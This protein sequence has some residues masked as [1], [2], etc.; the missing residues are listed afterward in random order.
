MPKRVSEQEL[1]QVEDLLLKHP[2]G[3][4][5]GQLRKLSDP[6]VSASTLKRRLSQLE[7][8]GRIRRQGVG[9]ATRYFHGA[10]ATVLRPAVT[11]REPGHF[12][13]PDG[14]S[15]LCCGTMASRNLP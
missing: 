9:R 7:K 10:A 4:S 15:Y 3:L 1:K 2:A 11:S 13:T 12:E 5:A 14:W 6:P 8:A